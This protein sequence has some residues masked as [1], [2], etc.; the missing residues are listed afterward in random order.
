[1]HDSQAKITEKYRNALFQQVYE[2]YIWKDWSAVTLIHDILAAEKRRQIHF[3]ASLTDIRMD[4]PINN[5]EINRQKDQLKKMRG[6][7]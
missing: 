3:S 5:G 1:M 4:R 7:I 2:L 6:L